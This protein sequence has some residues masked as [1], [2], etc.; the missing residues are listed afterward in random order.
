[1]LKVLPDPAPGGLPEGTPPM[2]APGSYLIC[3]GGLP[4]TFTA[5]SKSLIIACSVVPAISG[6]PCSHRVLASMCLFQTLN[7]QVDKILQPDCL[8]Q[9][10]AGPEVYTSLS[11]SLVSK[12]VPSTPS[13]EIIF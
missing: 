9:L 7:E 3:P 4:S 11:R 6:M 1:M 5:A 10:E 2:L 13:L 12:G 8:L